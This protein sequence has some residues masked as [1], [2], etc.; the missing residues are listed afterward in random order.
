[1]PKLMII[2]S[3]TRP[4]RLGHKIADWIGG[5][6]AQD[7]DWDVMEVDL[8]DLDLPMLDE[9]D[10]PARGNY[11]NPHTR[12]WSAMVD[13]ADAFVVVTPEYNHGIP[14]SLKNAIDFLHREWQYKPM[15]FV[16]YGGVS[17]GTRAVQML[18]QIVSALKIVPIVEAVNIPFF[19][20]MID[21]DGTFVPEPGLGDSARSMLGEV[22]KWTGP[23]AGMREA[24]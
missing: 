23:L 7:P 4:E 14:A 17:A 19:A 3:S 5:I 9:P 15:G 2:T 16:S 13:S 10:H 22:K 21:G 24:A 20:R 18:K 11:R 12:E 8:K 1:M 6:A